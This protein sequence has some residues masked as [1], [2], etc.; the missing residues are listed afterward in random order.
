M[1]RGTRSP[2]S[3]GLAAPRLRTAPAQARGGSS[4]S[5]ISRSPF[6]APGSRSPRSRLA[7]LPAGDAALPAQG[8]Q[9]VPKLLLSARSRSP[10]ELLPPS[11]HGAAVRRAGPGRRRRAGAGGCAQRPV[12]AAGGAAAQPAPLC[13]RPVR[14]FLRG[15]A[16][17]APRP[18]GSGARPGPGWQRGRC[19]P[20]S[21][22]LQADSVHR[23]AVLR[24]GSESRGAVWILWS[25]ESGP[26]RAVY[27]RSAAGVS[28]QRVEPCPPR[29]ILR[30]FFDSVELVIM[31]LSFTW[32][33]EG[34]I[35]NT[36]SA[37]FIAV[38]LLYISVHCNFSVLQY[39]KLEMTHKVHWVQLS[40]PHATAWNWNIWS[41]VF[42]R[43]CLSS[44]RFGAVTLLRSQLRWLATHVV[45]NL[46][47]MHSVNLPWCSVIPSHALSLVTINI[48]SSPSL[49]WRR[50]H[51]V[52]PQP[53][54]S[55][56]NQA[57]LDALLALE[58]LHHLDCLPQIQSNSFM[59]FWYRGT[60]NCTQDLDEA[61]SV[62]CRAGQ[63][64]SLS[65]WWCCAW[66]Q[67]HPRIQLILFV[68]P[69]STFHQPRPPDFFLWDCHPA[70][71][72]LALC[73]QVGSPH[74]RWRISTCSF[75]ID[76]CPV[77]WS[78]HMSLQGL[79]AVKKLQCFS[80]F[81]VG[82]VLTVLTVMLVMVWLLLQLAI[83]FTQMC[84]HLPPHQGAGLENQEENKK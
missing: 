59:S 17:T 80:N 51:E 41:R 8:R 45:K 22:L 64:P 37:L 24:Q 54:L 56:A 29:V 9:A 25:S 3:A 70:F 50:C 16:G 68:D 4:A 34:I 66:M 32:R 57:T 26:P 83:Q 33:R 72:A 67:M 46:S 84:S 30:V 5:R 65:S 20:V 31:L 81:K 77:F 28:V 78:F 10:P 23:A 69:Y 62:P 71:C 7:A 76:S 38:F 82:S 61:P 13:G 73:I 75:I 44:D 60:W 48:S 15:A 12:T 14:P 53:S 18:A 74:H 1:T 58:T 39:L 19:E 27:L 63:S 79:S 52:T 42:S 21:L 40:A 35:M 36:R 47:I 11:R 43:Y 55:W 2:H 6:P 49:H